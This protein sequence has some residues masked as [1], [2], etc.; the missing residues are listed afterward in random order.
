MKSRRWTRVS[1]RMKERMRVIV[2]LGRRRDRILEAPVLELEALEELVGDYEK[3]EMTCAAAAL[4][5]RLEWYRGKDECGS[6]NDE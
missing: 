5:R 3:A 2:E 6:M 1:P 4:R